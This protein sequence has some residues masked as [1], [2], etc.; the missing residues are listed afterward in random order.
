MRALFTGGQPPG[1]LLANL[2]GLLDDLIEQFG[3]LAHGA[4]P[5]VRPKL[6]SGRSLH[7]LKLPKRLVNHLV[8]GGEASGTDLILDEALQVFGQMDF[9]VGTLPGLDHL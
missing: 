8:L 3:I 4:K 7:F 2:H 6:A 1:P 5:R 9:H